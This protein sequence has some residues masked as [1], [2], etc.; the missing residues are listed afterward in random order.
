[1]G[2]EYVQYAIWSQ[3]FMIP[4]IISI[5]G[6]GTI[7]ARGVGKLKICNSVLTI[8]VI[9]NLAISIG[10]VP[11]LGIG[12][13]ILG[14]VVAQVIFGDAITFPFF[15]RICRLYPWKVFRDAIAIICVNLPAALIAFVLV[16]RFHINGWIQIITTS[17]I[18][19]IVFY[20]TLLLLFV[21]ERE[22]RD[23]MLALDAIGLDRS[24]GL[25]MAIARLLGL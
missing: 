19:L 10:S 18:L 5:F 4:I 7:I 13:P 15:C 16:N 22:K 21:K 2:D 17:I 9:V 23:L 6:I 24:P 8:R 14:T 12:G 1:M 3:L 20:L 11:Y 25:R